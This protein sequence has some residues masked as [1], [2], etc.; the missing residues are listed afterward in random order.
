M[1]A[2]LQLNDRLREKG[3]DSIPPERGL[4][5]LEQ[6]LQQAA[7]QV[8]VMPMNWSRFLER[9][10][11]ISPFFSELYDP[12]QRRQTI[13]AEE[14]RQSLQTL[15]VEERH[16]AVTIHLQTQAA[17]ILG[18]GTPAQV[19]TD[20]RLVDLGL[21]SL[22][23]IEFLSLLQSSLG[24]SFSSALLFDRPTIDALV[25]YV[26]KE[27]VEIPDADGVSQRN[28]KTHSIGSSTA[29][30]IQPEGAK[31]PLF[32][33]AGIL[34]SVFDFYGLARYLGK[35]R[36]VYGLRSQGLM[37]GETPLTSMAEI[38]EQQIQAI[39]GIQPQGPYHLA[40]HSFG[41]KVAFE[42]ARQLQE[43]GEVVS[44]LA[45]LDIPAVLAGHDR[46]IDRWDDPQYIVQL[47]E[48]Y[49]GT[50]DVSFDLS[51]E[52]LQALDTDDRLNL[53]LDRLQ[54]NGQKLTRTE[55]QQ[56]F[57]VYRSNMIADT[58]Y[59]PQPSHIPITLLRAQDMGDLDFLPDAAA[60][61]HDPTWGWHQR[62]TQPIDLHLI[63]GNHF[64]IVKEP[65]VQILARLL[66][67][68]MNFNSRT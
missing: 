55:L 31:L 13:S 14:F 25:D 38:A 52:Q 9:T 53:L 42:M 16:T 48:I 47:A 26:L 66:N 7:V 40:G 51:L 61:Q 58:A 4:H 8:G 56:I 44:F 37:P 64:T 10:G 68:K 29:I 54:K 19:P 60:T 22:M 5:I 24:R 34:G 35:E 1:T 33:V 36:P 63:P 62:S 18:I 23:A 11:A 20:K 21:D 30:A 49:G 12:S 46:A 15:P 57:S 3:E 27:W 39:Q 2:A 65:H 43:R 50:S 45:I 28:G 41:G 17:K 32:C 67:I 6:L 59:V